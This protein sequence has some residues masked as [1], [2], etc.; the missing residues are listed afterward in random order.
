M[1]EL[2]D[3]QDLGS[4]AARCAGSTPVT[5]IKHHTEK[6]LKNILKKLKKGIDKGGGVWYNNK[7]VAEVIAKSLIEN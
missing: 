4:C 2:A 1:A 5:R 7:A 3:A 6:K